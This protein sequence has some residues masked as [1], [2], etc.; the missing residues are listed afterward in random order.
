MKKSM[1]VAGLLAILGV[2]ENTYAATSQPADTTQNTSS[3]TPTTAGENNQAPGVSPGSSTQQ[4]A[5]SGVQTPTQSGVQTP[6]Q[7][8]VQTPTQP[9]VQTPAQPGVQTPAQSGVQTPA[10]PGVQTPAQ[11]GAQTPAQSGA[12]TPTQSGTQ[13]SMIQPANKVVTQPDV[14]VLVEPVKQPVIDCNY[15]IPAETTNIEQSVIQ[16]WAAKATE[17]SFDFDYKTIN[18]QLSGLKSCFTEQGWKSFNDALQSSG[19]LK[20]I[21]SEK[22][23]VNGMIDGN[24]TVSTVKDNQWKVILPLQVVYQNEKEKLNQ[25][26]TITL[27]VGR[28]VSGNLGIMQMVAMPRQPATPE[29]GATT[30]DSAAPTDKTTPTEKAAAQ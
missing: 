16:T 28:K 26:L 21:Q 27:V 2:T 3:P 5:Q 13:D 6:T 11:P 9:G 23:M 25:S 30:T 14:P 7:P 15:K 19:N 8:G 1:L 10:Q 18:E 22:L 17:Q 29:S 4:P 12:Q 20:V 24:I